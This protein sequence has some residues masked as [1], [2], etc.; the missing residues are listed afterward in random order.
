MLSHAHWLLHVFQ[1]LTQT[2]DTNIC[3][4]PQL[5][6]NSL[7]HADE[8]PP[9]LPDGKLLGSRRLHALLFG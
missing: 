3:A 1:R 8:P 4:A 7:Y 6:Y 9:P 2:T 5:H